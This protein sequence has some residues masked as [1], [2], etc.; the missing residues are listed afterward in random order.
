MAP[1]HIN[2]VMKNSRF[3]VLFFAYF[4]VICSANHK[5]SAQILPFDRFPPVFSY[6]VV[7]GITSSSFTGDS[8]GFTGV[9]M[10]YGGIFLSVNFTP[11]ISVTTD[12][13]YI[14]KGVN[15][16]TPYQKYR[17][18]YFS[19]EIMAGYLLAGLI[20]LNAG[21]R[22]G[23][24]NT[25]KMAVLNG[26][27]PSGVERKEIKGFGNWG[28]FIVGTTIYFDNITALV[29]RYGFTGLDIPMTHFQVGLRWN[30]DR[31]GPSRR[32]TEDAA[33]RR[34]ASINAQMLKEGVLLVRLSSM[35]TSIN[36]LHENGLVKE[37]EQLKTRTHKENLMLINA[38]NRYTFSRVLFFYDYNSNLVRDG[39]LDTILLN[40]KLEP[41]Q[42]D[43]SLGHIYTADL[44][45][46]SS[47]EKIYHV[48]RDP[49]YLKE[50]NIA[51]DSSAAY[52]AYNHQASRIG[53]IVVMDQKFQPFDS[54]FPTYTPLISRRILNPGAAMERA[55][56]RL[57]ESLIKI[58][59]SN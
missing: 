49:Q 20:Q 43:T 2:Y 3:I 59:Y 37:A 44:N 41:V 12:L 56:S 14:I 29:L 19:S 26:S 34:V 42:P 53:G 4:V 35:L 46:F 30:L 5:L 28:Q 57:N 52:I 10:P 27:F 18:S 32:T 8:T 58:L 15:R 55:V 31:W 7:G 33:R 45:H 25:S 50:N 23:F 54:P 51:P 1:N 40:N 16:D 48:Q 36:A 22:Y 38:F 11:E 6:G 47:Q 9:A 39:M 24:E 13:E 21:Y 17:Y